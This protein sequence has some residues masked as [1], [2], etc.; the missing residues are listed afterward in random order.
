MLKAGVFK[1]LFVILLVG[2]IVLTPVGSFA[3]GQPMVFKMAIAD[4][5]TMKVGDTEVTHPGYAA[6]QAFQDALPKYTSGKFKVEIYTGGRLGDVKSA[7]DQVQMGLIG[8]TQAA[9]GF[10][11]PYYKNIQILSAPYVFKNAPQMHKILDGPFGRKLFDDMAAKSGFRVLA[12]YENGG[13]RSFSNSKRVIKVP[14][15]MKG[16]KIR[17]MDSPIYM[18]FVK[19]TGASP[20]PVAWLELYSALQTGVVDGQEN[21][22]LTILSGSLQEVQKYYT[23]DNHVLGALFIVASEKFFKGLSPQLQKAFIKAGREASIAGRNSVRATENI[24]MEM[25]KKAGMQIY[26]PRAAEM[27]EWQKTREPALKWLRENT[28]QAMV[29]TLLKATK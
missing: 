5:P 1:N 27:K 16:L 11:A 24:A 23:L 21:S 4:P 10:I 7:M 15:D 17:T 14:K 18:E 9:D 26:T 12:T 25:L 28:D 19:A 8:A 29:D 13:F 22:A 2:L 3:A 20:V 6:M